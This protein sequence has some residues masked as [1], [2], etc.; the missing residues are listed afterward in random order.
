MQICTNNVSKKYEHEFSHEHEEDEHEDEH[1]Q[2]FERKNEQRTRNFLVHQPLTSAALRLRRAHPPPAGRG[3]MAGWRETRSD[4][5]GRG[6]DYGEKGGRKWWPSFRPIRAR[7]H[8]CEGVRASLGLCSA[9]CWPCG[10]FSILNLES[11]LGFP[12]TLG[13]HF[14]TSLSLDVTSDALSVGTVEVCVCLAFRPPATLKHR[15]SV[16]P[17][18]A[19]R[20]AILPTKHPRLGCSALTAV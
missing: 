9:A 12:T 11:L 6:G 20:P 2:R 3:P 17:P 14:F 10:R 7:V 15:S 16:V 4:E 18:R 19:N 13:T 8:F 1:E 5:H